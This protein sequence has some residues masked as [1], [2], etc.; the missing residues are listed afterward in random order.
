MTNGD[1]RITSLAPPFVMGKAVLIS[2]QAELPHS[3]LEIVR[4]YAMMLLHMLHDRIAMES[5]RF[6]ENFV[7]VI[8][9]R[10]DTG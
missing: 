1:A 6:D 8:A 9:G 7:G 5:S 2:H 3:V 10:D 4:L